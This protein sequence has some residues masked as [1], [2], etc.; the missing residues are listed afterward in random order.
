MHHRQAFAWVS[1][2][3]EVDRSFDP[4]VERNASVV[5]DSFE[6][7]GVGIDSSSSL[8][9]QHHYSSFHWSSSIVGAVAGAAFGE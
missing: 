2:A 4:F 8:E 3:S 7:R 9:A 6:Y 1:V 5:V